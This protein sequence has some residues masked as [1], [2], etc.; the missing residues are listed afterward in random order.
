MMMTMY[1]TAVKFV[2]RSRP[3]G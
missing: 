1:S 3:W 2:S